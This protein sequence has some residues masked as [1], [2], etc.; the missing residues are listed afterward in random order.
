MHGFV[1]VKLRSEEKTFTRGKK[2]E[3]TLRNFRGVILSKRA[4]RTTRRRKGKFRESDQAW[5]SLVERR[6][7][8]SLKRVLI[9]FVGVHQRL[10]INGKRRDN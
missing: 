9:I 5:R 7:A 10:P 8:K 4:W 1:C 2:E 6:K 3:E